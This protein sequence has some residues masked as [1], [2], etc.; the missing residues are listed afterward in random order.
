MALPV[1]DRP[2]A[3]YPVD[4]LVGVT[5]TAELI[6]DG[7]GTITG[8][9]I[10]L[11]PA[12]GTSPETLATF[13][14]GTKWKRFDFPAGT[15]RIRVQSI[16][17]EGSHRWETRAVVAPLDDV[18]GVTRL[19]NGTDEVQVVPLGED[20]DLVPS[21]DTSLAVSVYIC[22]VHGVGA[23]LAT[24]KGKIKVQGTISE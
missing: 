23:T 11:V 8:S 20:L 5:A 14:S 4:A 15:Y 19:F 6:I 1:E 18:D 21:L 24:C 2:T 13:L 7:S 12:Y 10:P 22:A 3:R 17:G 16:W 9:A